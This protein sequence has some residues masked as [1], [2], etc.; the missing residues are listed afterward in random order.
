M[1]VQAFGRK[2]SALLAALKSSK[3]LK[4]ALGNYQVQMADGLFG[5]LWCARQESNLRPF[6]SEANALSN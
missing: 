6:A 5:I 2:I 3:A 4:R 1:P